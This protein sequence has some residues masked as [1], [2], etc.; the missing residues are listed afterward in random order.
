MNAECRWQPATHDTRREILD[1][2]RELDD[3]VEFLD[4]CYQRPLE[5]EGT[6][7]MRDARRLCEA[8][9]TR[10]A[11]IAARRAAK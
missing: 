6:G 8:R 3:A 11:E 4:R 7:A 10:E 2:Y 9:H 1:A 5:C